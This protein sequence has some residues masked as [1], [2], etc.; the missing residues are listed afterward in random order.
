VFLEHGR[1]PR[2]RGLCPG[3][4]AVNQMPS[5]VTGRVRIVLTSAAYNSA[6]T[7]YSLYSASVVF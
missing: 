2:L 1:E 3:W 4:R 7:T 6:A 5:S